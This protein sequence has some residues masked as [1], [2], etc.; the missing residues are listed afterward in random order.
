MM[1]L[2]DL[3]AC[4]SERGGVIKFSLLFEVPKKSSV[5]TRVTKGETQIAVKPGADGRMSGSGIQQ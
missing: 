4:S 5:C 3:G 1:D 2:L